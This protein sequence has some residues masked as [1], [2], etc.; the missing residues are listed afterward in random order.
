MYYNDNTL[1]YLNG[2]MLQATETKGDLY[3][4]TLHYG[5][6]VFEGIRSYATE[7]GARIFK[8]R[9]HFERLHKSA[10]LMHITLTTSVDELTEA[11]YRVLHENK[12]QDA[13]LRPIVYLDANMRLKK[14]SGVNIMIAAWEWGS[15]LGDKQL[16]LCTS[17][18]ERPNPK[19]V[20]V[21]AKVNGHYVNSILATIQAKNSGFDEAL[22][23]DC[24]GFV[25]EGPG[26][27]L[28][29]EKNGKL[30]TPQLGNI[31][32]GITRATVLELGAELGIDCKEIQWDLHFPLPWELKWLLPTGKWLPLL[33]MGV[34][35]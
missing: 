33:A 34:S 25:A 4:Q 31:L 16:R 2:E 22:L 23:L 12:L 30:Y 21:E 17:P 29:M 32:P 6:G 15:Y 18:Y 3:G 13:Y 7:D 8:A 20:H 28:F 26:A 5:Y 24:N 10:E 9:E 35:R 1:I 19:S 14:P 11:A 27:N